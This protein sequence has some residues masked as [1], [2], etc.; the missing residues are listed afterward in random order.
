MLPDQGS[1]DALIGVRVIAATDADGGSR[2][3][4]KMQGQRPGRLRA[5]G[6]ASGGAATSARRAV[7]VQLVGVG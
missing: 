4:T 2:Q 5:T 7:R 3:D 6:R 1:R